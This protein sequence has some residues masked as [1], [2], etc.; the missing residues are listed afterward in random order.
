[1]FKTLKNRFAT[2][3]FFRKK[4]RTECIKKKTYCFSDFFVSSRSLKKGKSL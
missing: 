4:T 2:G 1:M 3:I